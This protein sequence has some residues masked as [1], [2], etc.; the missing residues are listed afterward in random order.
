VT[1]TKRWELH[2]GFE[3][4]T[5]GRTA[6]LEAMAN[7]PRL[8]VDDF[9]R[10]VESQKVIAENP[11]GFITRE[12]LDHAVIPDHPG[13]VEQVRR[14]GSIQLNWSMWT[15][16]EDE[17]RGLDDANVSDARARFMAKNKAAELA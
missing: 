9:G 15:A 1:A 8:R 5:D 13:D 14:D 17:M 11:C 6:F 7:L 12:L 4:T 3:E 2:H 16:L 10:D